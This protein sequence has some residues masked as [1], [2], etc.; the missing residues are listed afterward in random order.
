MLLVPSSIVDLRDL[1]A[2]ARNF[3]AK[4]S[5]SA[6]G[7][8]SNSGCIGRGLYSLTHGGGAPTGTRQE[9]P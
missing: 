7:A 5:C 6:V 2:P 8:R 1:N 9:R 3:C 4:R